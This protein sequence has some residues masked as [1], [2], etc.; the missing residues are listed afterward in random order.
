MVGNPAYRV[1]TLAELE[2]HYGPVNDASLRKEIDHIHPV[3]AALIE[4]APFAML[5]TA[6][7]GGLDASPRGDLGGVV[8]I[9]DARTLVL[10]DRR[11]NNRIDSLRNILE[12]P[13]VALLFL[14]P[15]LG[16]TL[17]VNGRAEISVDPDLLDRYAMDGNKPR[18]VLIVHVETVFFQCSRALIRSQLWNP[19]RHVPRSA[20]PSTGAILEA[21]SEAAIDGADY[22]RELPGRLKTTL[23]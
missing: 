11:G 2:P 17:R 19:E 10:P 16:E 1:T 23:Y 14:I 9:V 22:D 6:G 4:A 18:S 12:N 5:A 21:V 8:D 3:Y 15:G 7:A 20:L 13:A